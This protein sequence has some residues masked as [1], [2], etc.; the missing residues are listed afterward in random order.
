M[1]KL[2]L[3]MIA[4]SFA[5]NTQAADTA[6]QML[7][8][9]VKPALS[10][11][12]VEHATK[13]K[14]DEN[15]GYKGRT[16]NRAKTTLG[17]VTKSSNALSR[18]VV[19]DRVSKSN[20]QLENLESTAGELVQKVEDDRL[21]VAKKHE[22]LFEKNKSTLQEAYT[23]T[24]TVKVENLGSEQ[25][26]TIQNAFKCSNLEDCNKNTSLASNGKND[27]DIKEVC[28]S[29]QRLH[30]NGA[31]WSCLSVFKAPAVVTCASGTQYSKQVNGGTACI[32]YIFKWKKDGTF[33]ACTGADQT[34]KE[35]VSC[36]AYKTA[37]AT[38]SFKVADKYCHGSE[39][40]RPTYKCEQSLTGACASDA[41]ELANGKC[42]AV[43]AYCTKMTSSTEKKCN[44]ERISYEGGG[45]YNY[46]T[47][48]RNITS[49]FYKGKVVAYKTVHL[50]R[51]LS[52]STGDSY[53]QAGDTSLHINDKAL[54]DYKASQGHNLYGY[55]ENPSQG[56]YSA[57]EPT[58][59]EIEKETSC[60]ALYV[61]ANGKC[62]FNG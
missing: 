53:G 20:P 2:I 56:D 29:D 31:T 37:S 48:C 17:S 15:D 21:K 49:Y 5:L 34:I 11:I 59:I 47:V 52:L 42:S 54:F 23:I 51:R 39:P 41:T 9:E 10:A 14:A 22:T 60:P 12:N 45:R 30:W 55:I 16:L 18:T 40:I 25:D 32:D 46:G 50:S 44:R 35:E 6:T 27:H 61:K 3:L 19:L 28:T 33:P 7:E 43:R 13:Y 36:N 8:N 4:V 57:C 38:T 24:K 1:K 62:K 58:R 26:P